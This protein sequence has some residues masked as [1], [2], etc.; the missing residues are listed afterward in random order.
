MGIRKESI[1][2]FAM[3]WMVGNFS[4]IAA[5]N[6][7][8]IDSVYVSNI[9]SVKFHIAGNPLAFPAIPL[10]NDF[11]M[12]LSFDDM[13]TDTKDY[14]VSII[15][16]NKN[17][18]PSEQINELEYLT[19]YNNAPIREV[20]LAFN[21]FVNYNHYHISLPNSE[22]GWKISGNYLLK[23]IDRDDDDRV[24]I[25]RRFVVYEPLMKIAPSVT[26]TAEV[27]KSTTHQELDFEV[28][29]PG[30]TIRTPRT[31]LSA[32]VI[33]NNRWDN[34]IQGVT[35]V[36]VRSESEVFDYQD[37]IIFEAGKEFRFFDM[38]GLNILG[39]N[40]Q[41]VKRVPEGFEVVLRKER[42]NTDVAYLIRKDLNGN[43]VIDC[44]D[45][46]VEDCQIKGDYAYVIFTLTSDQELENKSVYITGALTDWQLKPEFKM[47]YNESKGQYEA[48]VLLKQG[49]Y[50][51]QFSV[52]DEKTKKRDDNL[53]QGNWF[54]T[55]NSFS[56]IVYYRGFGDRYDKPVAFG[57]FDSRKY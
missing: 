39:E 10:G 54:E 34:C 53:L 22:V 20:A 35:P 30:F 33:M 26:R 32:T 3:V 46:D 55:E 11:P 28:Q 1:L 49:Y 8:Y 25:T 45:I 44:Y 50:N 27:S 47:Q 31:E 4:K 19:G 43:F 7:A 5:Q 14:A 16:C 23:V 13:G 18:T 57:V 56:I 41:T 17:W 48:E 36:F 51:Y 15:H 12:V 9:K 2:F 42:I 38:R 52:F 37:K 40:M 29:H 6:F 24:V 21:T